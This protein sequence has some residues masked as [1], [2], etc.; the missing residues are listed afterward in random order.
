MSLQL[1]YG[2]LMER[3]PYFATEVLD[4]ALLPFLQNIFRE[5]DMAVLQMT[6]HLPRG[7]SCSRCQGTIRVQF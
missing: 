4:A 7:S 1:L 3:F 2:L 6:C 5:P